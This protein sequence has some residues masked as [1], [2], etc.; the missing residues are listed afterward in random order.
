MTDPV[1]R[2]AI[3]DDAAAIAEIYNQGLEDRLGTF[4]TTLRSRDDIAGWFNDGHP[5]IVVTDAS[6]QVAAFA[7]TF[8]YADRCVYSGIAEFSVYVRRDRRGL[9]LGRLAM[10]ALIEASTKAGF[11]KLLSR[12]FPENTASLALLKSVGFREV[13]VHE[14]HGRLDGV[15]RDVIAVELLIPAN[16]DV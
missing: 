7:A 4:E 2:P 3:M 10:T 13:G 11:W 15:W 9:G 5:M 6:V 8:P 1:A 14:K 12:V 16:Q